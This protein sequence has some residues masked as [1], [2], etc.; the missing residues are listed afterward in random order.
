V[1]LATS[2]AAPAIDDREKQEASI[3]RP[4]QSNAPV[5]AERGRD[6]GAGGKARPA[7]SSSKKRYRTGW[8]KGGVKVRG[9]GK[10]EKNKSAITEKKQGV[11]KG[12]PTVGQRRTWGEKRTGK[13]G[14]PRKVIDLLL[15][16]GLLNAV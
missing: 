7:A 16:S 6:A 3:K 13:G 10:S 4:N 2:P 12:A 9:Q 11:A 1:L 5:R 8:G 14:R 15:R